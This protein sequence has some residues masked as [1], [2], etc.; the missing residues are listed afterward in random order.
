MHSPSVIREDF[1][2]YLWRTK[3][4]PASLTLVD[5]RAVE[6]LDYGVYNLDAGPD[7]F[8]GR[9]RIEDTIWAGNI[10]MHV[11]SSDWIK[12]R[13][14][15]DKAYDNVILHVVYEMDTEITVLD[16][17][18]PTLV[19]RGSIP[20][21]Y[22]E[23]YGQ[24]MSST[25]VIPCASLIKAV[26]DAKIEM[27]KSR[28]TIERL[29]KK[30]QSLTDIIAYT[31][32]NWEETL[33]IVL[34]RYFG[35]KVNVEP[36]ER[37]ARSLTLS[38]L[39]KNVDKSLMIAALLFGQAGMLEANYTDAYYVSLKKE[40]RFA[41]AKY[42]LKPIDSSTWKFG[43]LRPPN[44]PTVRLAQFAALMV[45]VEALFSHIRAA[46]DSASLKSIF[47]EVVSD[48]YWDDHY[49]FGV[50]S[51]YQ[52]KR[53]T[54]EFIDLLIINAVVPVIFAYGKSIDDEEVSD[55]AIHLLSSISAESNTIVKSYKSL[56]VVCSSA[57]ESQ[58][59]LQLNTYYCKEHRCA[60]CAIGHEILRS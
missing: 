6:I 50:E 13:H 31:G 46:K 5:G 9:I 2:H 24:M 36:F 56:G 14:Q 28:L 52:P 3:M 12:H 17:K 57:A 42:D 18:L 53:L 43:K 51:T 44:F 34:A 41:Q 55:R 10:E 11:A 58:A 35:S 21:I 29:E 37:V 26:P 30:S 7:F 54:P 15:H 27:W 20:R 59:L 25:Q 49:R 39:L 38:I 16:H 33:Y 48:K 60:Q 47:D 4:V 45:K 23:R 1:L 8:N 32:H 19:L 40:Y 22:L